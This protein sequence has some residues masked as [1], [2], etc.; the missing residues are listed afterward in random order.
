M[1]VAIDRRYDDEYKLKQVIREMPMKSAG[2][3]A[4]RTGG[5]A[6][7]SVGLLYLHNRIIEEGCSKM[8]KD[9]EI[10]FEPF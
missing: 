10:L 7:R 3:D 6:D 8:K 4:G 2:T 5:T 1:L 9:T